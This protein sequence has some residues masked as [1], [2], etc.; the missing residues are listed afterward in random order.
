MWDQGRIRDEFYSLAVGKQ[1]GEEVGNVSKASGDLFL[2]RRGVSFSHHCP[3]LGPFSHSPL[4][5]LVC[6]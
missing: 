1:D 6:D 2:L 5:W 4:H 3:F